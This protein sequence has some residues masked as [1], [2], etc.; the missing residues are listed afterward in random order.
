MLFIIILSSVI[1]N[2][3]SNVKIDTIERDIYARFTDFKQLDRTRSGVVIDIIQDSYGYVWFAGNKCLSR[4]DGSTIRYYT[5]D[6]TPESLPSTKI[7]SLE[8][9]SHGRLLVGTD[10][11]LCIYNYD[12]DEF[13]IIYGSQKNISNVDSLKIRKVFA[14]GDSLI[15]FDTQ[16]GY[17]IKLNAYNY[18]VISKYKHGPT[19]QPYY[20]YNTIF[21]DDESRIWIGCRGKGPYILNEEKGTFIGFKTSEFENIHGVKRSN[22]V[23]YF[24]IDHQN[25]F[26]IGSSDGVYLFDRKK[27]SFDLFYKTSSWS[28]IEDEEG[29][30]WFGVSS[31]LVRY[32]IESKEA[33]LYLPNEEDIGSLKGDYIYKIYEDNNNQVWVSGSNGISV[34]KRRTKGVKYLFHISGVNDSPVSSSI[35]DMVQ[36]SNGTVWIATTKHGID[37]YNPIENSFLH[38]NTKT[39]NTFPSDKVRCIALDSRGYLYCGFW[40]G[41]GFGY[42]NPLSQRFFLYSYSEKSSINDWYNDLLFI[43]NSDLYLGLWGA[44]GLTKFDVAK[45]VFVENYRNKFVDSEQARLITC[46]ESD[47]NNNLWMGT[48]TRGVYLYFPK[49][50]TSISFYLPLNPDKGITEKKIF[51]LQKDNTGNIWIA[52]RN[53]YYADVDN[54]VIKTINLGSDIDEI[55]IYNVLIENENTIWLLSDLGLLKYNNKDNSLIDYSSA[56]DISFLENNA[57][58]I[59]L[60]DGR[61][62]FGGNDGITIIEP[63]N[64]RIG[65][66]MPEVYLSSLSVYDKVSIAN[67]DV[68]D[69]IELN[70]NENF[71]TINIGANVWGKEDTYKFSYKL[72][73]FNKDWISISGNSKQAIFTNVPPGEYYFNVHVEDKQGNINTNAASCII[74]VNSP[75]WI[76]WWFIVILILSALSLI[77]F[78]LW[79]RM[80]SIRLSLFNSELNQKLLRLQMNPHFIFNSL[81]AIQNYIYSEQTHLAGIY[82]SDFAHLIRLI[83]DNSRKE[84]IDFET[85]INTLELYLKL[86]KLRF[87]DNFD[88]EFIID[89]NLNNA[90]YEIPPMLA[91]PFIEN[92]IEHGFKNLNR[93]GKMII[94]YFLSGDIIHFTLIDNGIG[95]D[96]S[97]KNKISN[98]EKHESL[99]IAIC[100]Q[101]IDILHKKRK[102]KIL[103]SIKEI[104][105]D[106]GKVDGTVVKFNIPI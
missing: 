94:K 28:M 82:L 77:S 10:K 22:D 83:L 64:I 61:L 67:I 23:S 17:L 74:I 90:K 81:F 57:A 32:N 43:S 1:A 95:F 66:K 5:D 100:K 36:D 39:N 96:E 51:A 2:A 79:M 41:T 86:Q 104:I 62:M 52:G 63:K 16:Q 59:K 101:R 33:I 71:F 34:L 13:N 102:S 4:F 6:W 29:D 11:G 106:K 103:F 20:H 48:T 53:L 78:V 25:N 31:G 40:S 44:D 84:Y 98:K 93:K 19:S 15:W 89:P 26:W 92:A 88:Y 70:H 14:D 50:D 80:K 7:N 35:S 42:Y 47:K 99:A 8:C 55:E 24:H 9:D 105:N 69:T 3:K 56:V 58:G 18:N 38:I 12:N 21:R 60:N 54:K 87:E 49:E 97:N 76:R 37:K 65:K 85:E 72:E 75:F 91:Q 68:R 27:M 73:G 45:E 30:L 46:L